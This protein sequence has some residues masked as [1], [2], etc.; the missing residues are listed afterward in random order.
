MLGYNYGVP[1]IQSR[2]GTVPA[3][4][5]MDNVACIGNETSLLDCPHNSQDD[6]GANEGAGVICENCGKVFRKFLV[7][8]SRVIFWSNCQKL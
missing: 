3:T 7:C 1:T 6:C 2:F 8:C 4:F 5:A